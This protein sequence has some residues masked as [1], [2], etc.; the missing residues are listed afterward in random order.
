MTQ[1][2]TLFPV[3]Y[4]FL[5]L[6]LLAVAQPIFA[7]PNVLKAS[8][9]DTSQPL[10]VLASRNQAGKTAVD[11]ERN[12]AFSAGAD[13]LN[14]SK[15]PDAAPL[16]GAL[17]G[18]TLLSSFDGQSA[19]DNR[20]VLGF[21]YVPPDTNGA[22]GSNQYVQMVNVTIAVYNKSNGILQLGPA[23]IHTIWK[24]F[25]GPCEN[26]PFGDGGDPVV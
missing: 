15:D 12:D 24:D 14:N 19:M 22:V 13:I 11:K 6:L 10:S 7:A 26:E 21:A 5:P 23:P 17:K 18:V 9:H 4:L 1:A 3:R 25:G 8:R 20:R 16:A 2:R